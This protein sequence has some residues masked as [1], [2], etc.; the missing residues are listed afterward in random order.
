MKIR[1]NNQR[2]ELL[3]I[4]EDKFAKFVTTN[5]PP[6]PMKYEKI[7]SINKDMISCDSVERSI[8]AG[9]NS[10]GIRA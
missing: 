1:T 2:L 3:T 6:Q 5:L 4:L 10:C 8:E 9:P 7:V